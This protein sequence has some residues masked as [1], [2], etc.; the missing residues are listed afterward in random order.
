[1][2]YKVLPRETYEAGPIVLRPVAWEDREAIRNWRNA[3]IAVLRQKAPISPADQDAYF[4][5]DVLPDF[6]ADAPRNILF[7]IFEG[8]LHIGYG[9]L[10]HIAWTDLRAEVSFLLTPEL[11]GTP[12]ETQT[13]LPAFHAAMKAVAFDDLGFVKLT[14]ETYAYRA[15][16]LAAYEGMGYRPA[17]RWTAHVFHEGRF[18]DAW[19]HE[20]LCPRNLPAG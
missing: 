3:Q 16:F 13:Y 14:L 19:L 9:G 18:H 4:E 15:A 20:C 8:G 5:R 17:G 12:A 2:G 11:A 7:S 6:H 1:M 10:V